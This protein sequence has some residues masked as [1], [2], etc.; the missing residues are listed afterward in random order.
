MI[1][2]PQGLSGTPGNPITIR[3]R[4]DGLVLI[5]GQF[6]R[7]PVSLA[8]R[9]WWV[10]EGFNAK[11]S[12]GSV[13]NLH[14]AGN[15]ILRRVI[16]WDSSLDSTGDIYTMNATS[17]PILLE[18]SAGF[19]TA[20]FIIETSQRGNNITVRRFW[21]RFEGTRNG[22][23]PN[24]CVRPHYNN[25]N[26]TF[27]N[28]FCEWW[29]NS[30]P[31]NYR[32][33][34]QNGKALGTATITDGG[35]PETGSSFVLNKH[36]S[37]PH[38]TNIHVL[39]SMGYIQAGARATRYRSAWHAANQGADQGYFDTHL[40][41]VI[42]FVDPAHPSFGSLRGF[43]LGNTALSD[44]FLTNYTSIRN[45]DTIN[46]VWNPTRGSTGTTVGAVASPWATAGNGANL[47]K[48]YTNRSLTN[49]PLWPWPMNERIKAV[50]AQPAYAGPCG[51]VA[52]GDTCDLSPVQARPRVDLTATMER[53]FGPIP[54]ACRR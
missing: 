51:N 18:D 23:N 46:G 35:I 39:G 22:Q 20:S 19:G 53:F 41:H 15:I 17:G 28:V 24:S 37:P 54:T 44:N 3:A 1:S 30:Q 27:E 32:E 43:S 47:C 6:L 45:T 34:W 48:R 4:N 33:L 8:G 12:S 25:F 31:N 42:A 14:S 52:P 13:F 29:N 36:I 16:G 21:G 10:L 26:N 50:T 9:Q 11:N 2:P 7:V 40:K 38:N 49:D 5:D